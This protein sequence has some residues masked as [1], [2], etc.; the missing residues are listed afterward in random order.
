MWA[1]LKAGSHHTQLELTIRF[2]RLMVSLDGATGTFLLTRHLAPMNSDKYLPLRA[3][4][5]HRRLHHNKR[6]SWAW[7]YFYLKRG[8]CRSP[9]MRN[10][11]SP[12]HP[13]RHPHAQGET[14]TLLLPIRLLTNYTLTILNHF[15][16]IRRRID[17]VSITNAQKYSGA[18]FIRNN[19]L[20]W[21]RLGR[22][23]FGANKYS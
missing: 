18:Y 6:E 9:P 13:K 15:A 10:A 8:E 17:Y 23:R 4:P 21:S 12:Y 7:G 14:Q 22:N 20:N 1:S 5:P 3:H 19:L 16:Y 11:A 2:I